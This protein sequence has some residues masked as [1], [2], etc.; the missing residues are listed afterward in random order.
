VDPVFL[1]AEDLAV[2]VNHQGLLGFDHASL[3]VRPI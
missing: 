2:G 3:G 1:A